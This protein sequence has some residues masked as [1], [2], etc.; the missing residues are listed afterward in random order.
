VLLGGEGEGLGFEGEFFNIVE[1][2]EEIVEWWCSIIGNFDDL[3]VLAIELNDFR[4]DRDKICLHS[5]KF[6]KIYCKFKNLLL[7]FLALLSFHVLNFFYYL[8]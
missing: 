2:E 8:I 4:V 5:V 1:T 3:G 6:K 7:N